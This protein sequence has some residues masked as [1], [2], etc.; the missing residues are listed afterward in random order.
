MAETVQVQQETS[1]PEYLA[2]SWQHHGK[3]RSYDLEVEQWLGEYPNLLD[4][5]D[6]DDGSLFD[7]RPN[8]GTMLDDGKT[9][10]LITIAL[11]PRTLERLKA[12]TRERPGPRSNNR[13]LTIEGKEIDLRNRA[14]FDLVNADIRNVE[15]LARSY[16]HQFRTRPTKRQRRRLI[17]ELD[18]LMLLRGQE[19]SR[20]LYDSIC[21][22]L[23]MEVPPDFWHLPSEMLS[24]PEL[25]SKI[26]GKM[27]SPLPC[28]VENLGES[29]CVE[30]GM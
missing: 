13:Q 23:G 30:V 25:V 29:R 5:I 7:A 26:V 22:R 19:L 3:A 16:M 6:A 21:L 2:R 9:P 18:R 17:C 20:P 15:N 12:A 27:R 28:P 8:S 14:N 1:L 24:D 10:A 11:K 4:L